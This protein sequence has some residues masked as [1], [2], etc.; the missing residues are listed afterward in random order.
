MHASGAIIYG[1][2]NEPKEFITQ[3]RNSVCLKDTETILNVHV[4]RGTGVK[5]SLCDWCPYQYA[6]RA[7]PQNESTVLPLYQPVW[8]PQNQKPSSKP[9]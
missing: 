7:P 6:N 2:I 4:I 5:P 9:V 8:S 1:K 3:N